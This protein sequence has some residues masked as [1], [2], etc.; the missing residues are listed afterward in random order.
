MRVCLLCW[1]MHIL[2]VLVLMLVVN[3]HAGLVLG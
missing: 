2:P 1:A 3:R